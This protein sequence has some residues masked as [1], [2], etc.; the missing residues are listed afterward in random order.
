MYVEYTT[1]VRREKAEV[2]NWRM[3][4]LAEY[5][6]CK[7]NSG[8]SSSVSYFECA[9]SKQPVSVSVLVPVDT[10]SSHSWVRTSLNVFQ[11]LSLGDCFL[12]L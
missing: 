4:V 5:F 6:E 8:R 12:L 10:S 3:M 2:K 7:E 9:P 11:V 1:S